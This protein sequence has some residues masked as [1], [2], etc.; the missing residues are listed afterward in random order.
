MTLERIDEAIR[1]ATMLQGPGGQPV[2]LVVIGA[3]A[4]PGL[5]SPT[6][7]VVPIE[8][9]SLG[10][11][12]P[13]TTSAHRFHTMIDAL[14]ADRLLFHIFSSVDQDCIVQ[15]IGSYANTPAD[16]QSYAIIG[17]VGLLPSGSQHVYVTPDL[18]DA[19]FPWLGLVIIPLT[20]PTSGS[21]TA[22]AY[23][24]RWRR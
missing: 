16:A 13:R 4:L 22:T 12:T 23:G 1:Q 10:T 7:P 6:A 2:Y 24:R 3:D 19:Y 17:E 18:E 20:A 21:I 11:I 14:L 8:G 15:L 5:V 9:E